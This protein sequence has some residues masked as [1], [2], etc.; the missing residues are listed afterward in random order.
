MRWDEMRWHKIRLDEAKR[1]EMRWDEI[2][3][4]QIDETDE[5]DRQIYIHYL[6]VPEFTGTKWWGPA[7]HYPCQAPRRTA[8]TSQCNQDVVA[9]LKYKRCFWFSC[10]PSFDYRTYPKHHQGMIQYPIH[11]AAWS[12]SASSITCS[13]CRC[14]GK[15]WAPTF[16]R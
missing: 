4:D 14:M 12:A 16:T 15:I 13:W 2:R 7:A 8:K 5:T 1:D 10:K 3:R 9:A 6:G 11:A